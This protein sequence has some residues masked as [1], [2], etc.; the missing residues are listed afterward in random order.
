MLQTAITVGLALLSWSVDAPSLVDRR[1]DLSAG[2][3]VPR[4]P[5]DSTRLIP[6]AAAADSA[7]AAA[8]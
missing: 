5:I 4:H 7:P 6:S 1:L 8:R 2:V 3:V